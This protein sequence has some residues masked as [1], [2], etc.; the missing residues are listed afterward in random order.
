MNGMTD[1]RTALV[2]GGG[3]AGPVVAMALQRAGISARIYEAYRGNSAAATGGMISL[4][5]NGVSA[6]APIGLDDAVRG[7]GVPNSSIVLHSWTGKRLAEFGA[8]PGMPPSQGVWREEMFRLLADAAVRRGIPMEHGRRFVRAEDHG[9]GVTAYF[10]DGSFASADILIGADG[11]HST[12]RPLIDP[13]A[14]EPHYTGLLGF[15]GRPSAA[16]DTGLAPTDGTL[17]MSFGKRAFFAYQVFDDGR[18]SWFANL[19][20]KEPLTGAQARAVGAQEWLRVLRAAFSDDRTPAAHILATS[21]PEDLI[22]VGAQEDLPSVP[23]WSRGRMVLIGD[24]AHATA[25]RSPSRAPC[26]SPAAC[27][28][29]PC[30]TPSP[31]TRP[32]AAPGSSGS[33]PWPPAPT[34]TR[35]PGRSDGWSATW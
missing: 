17:H 23:T 33:S 14:P 13:A 9:D 35:Q 18:T 6:L 8:L 24:A 15:G 16:C 19:P 4:A 22:V 30:R 29:S 25:P 26:S 3:I 12:V 1:V 28:T 5:P 10:A 2:I 11:I 32:C 27:A 20:R 31:P 34:A 7:M 21:S